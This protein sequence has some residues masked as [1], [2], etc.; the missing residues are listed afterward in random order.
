MNGMAENKLV[1]GEGD[2]ITAVLVEETKDSGWVMRWNL[3]KLDRTSTY[4]NFWGNK[5][6]QDIDLFY[7]EGQFIKTIA[8]IN[9]GIRITFSNETSIHCPLVS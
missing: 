9:N 3:L 1:I 7:I 5:T 8:V 2:R 4:Q 6:I